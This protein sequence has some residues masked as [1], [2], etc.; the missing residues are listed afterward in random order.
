MT[1]TGPIRLGDA[2]RQ[3][4]AEAMTRLR[5]ESAPRD[6]SIP[7]CL[8]AFVGMVLL[9]LTPAIGGYVQIP[10]PVVMAI[11]VGAVVLLFAGAGLGVF[12]RDVSPRAVALRGTEAS[13]GPILAWA[14]SGGD[15]A[16]AVHAS[17]ALIYHARYP[18]PVGPQPSWDPD[19]M[20]RRLGGRGTAL[21]QAVE[22]ELQK[23]ES[24]VRPVFGPTS[25]D[26]GT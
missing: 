12:G 4:I 1:S 18:T 2:D 10:R 5:G 3:A 11:F 21:V 13:V 20:M 26:P 15:Q 22:K 7:G 9:T 24:G 8:T 19:E 23:L 6:P 16:G 17:V 25:S 14:Q